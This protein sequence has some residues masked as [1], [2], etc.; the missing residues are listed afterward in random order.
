MTSEEGARLQVALDL[1][2][3]GIA[4]MR[5]KLR[6]AYPDASEEKLEAAGPADHR[7]RDPREERR[8]LLAGTGP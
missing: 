7:S 5:S 1:H 6:R 8:A 4:L 3:G 2:E